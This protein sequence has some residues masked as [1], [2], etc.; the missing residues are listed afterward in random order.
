MNHL[1]QDSAPLEL[2]AWL[3][4]DSELPGWDILT[5]H[6]FGSSLPEDQLTTVQ[7]YFAEYHLEY[8]RQRN[9]QT[10]PSRLHALLLFA[11]RVDAETFRSKHPAHVFGK[12]LVRARSHGAYVCSFHDASW[13]DYLRLPHSLSLA[14]LEEVVNHYWRGTLVEE[15]GLRFM[16][17]A[18]CEPPVIEALFQ[19]RLERVQSAASS[20]WLPGFA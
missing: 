17:E 14:A 6:P 2:Y 7:N 1:I 4:A 12:H 5:D 3:A 9:F 8:V 19:G 16:D 11:T 20:R 18:W 15:V 13:L 10:F